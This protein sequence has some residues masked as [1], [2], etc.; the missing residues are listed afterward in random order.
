[1]VALLA[2]HLAVGL[3]VVAAGSRLGRRAVVPAV[4][5]PA[6]ALA[7]LV[8]HAGPVLGG[9][10][11]VESLAWVPALDVDLD[12]RLD[13]F[14]ALFVLLVAGI[15]VL[16][17]AYAG[18]YLDPDDPGAGRLVGLLVL[19]AGSML[20]LVLADN[21]IVLFGFWELTSLT[22]FLL[23]GNDHT[24]A[25]ARAA[26]LQALL[27]TGAGG[28]ALLAGVV[29]VGQAAGTYSLAAVVADPP[30]GA[31]VTVG[32]VLVLAGA[33]TKSAQYPFQSWLPAA[34]VAPTP[35]SAYLHSATMVTAGVYLVGRLSPA[36]AGVDG[37][38][39]L[40]VTVGLVSMLA[41]GLRALRQHDLKLLLAHGTVSQLGFMIVLLG[42][43][44]PAALVAGCAL[45]LA[46]G[47]FKAA[48]FMVVGIVDHQAGTR[49]V[50]RLGPLGPR[51]APG[52]GC[53]SGGGGVDGGRAAHVRLRRQGG[54][55]RRPGRLP[56]SP[57]R[58]SCWRWWWRARR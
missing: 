40:V 34:M 37:W 46:H 3:A 45:I 19:F 47:V 54:G 28:L 31:A 25:P 18:R 38:R 27:V 43:G 17:L 49:D 41:G 4:V 55:L 56:R 2:L 53:R 12:L 23:I 32:L 13:G 39:P 58:P 11:I 57:A 44:T 29:L 16:V 7:W 33:F 6:A 15:G 35:V 8:A 48:L 36:F 51:L 22:S 26:A 52:A 30:A 1:M 42:L 21:L 5:A 50:R 10:Q 20:G 24:S 9:E 14:A